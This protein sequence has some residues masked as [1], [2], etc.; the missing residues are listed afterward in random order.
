MAWTGGQFT[1]ANGSSEWVN[2]ANLLIGIEPGR[3]DAQDNDLATGINQCI[4]KD[5]SN[6]FTGD[7]NLG[8][9]KPTNIAAGTATAPALCVGGDVNTGVFA[10]AADTWA[11]A[12]NG[13]ER[14][15][16][17]STGFCSINE[18]PDATFRLRVGGRV[19]VGGQTSGDAELALASQL[20]P[21]NTAW[22]WSVRSDVGGNND[23]LKLIRFTSGSFVGTALQ[24][25]NSTGNVA[26]GTST[27]GG[28]LDVRTA[29]N[30]ADDFVVGVNL[31][32][33]NH[34]FKSKLIGR[35]TTSG[36]TA[37]VIDAGH[38]VQKQTSSL[39]YKT[40][41]QD[42]PKGLATVKQLRPVQYKGIND[43][44]KI[45]AGLIAE[46]VHDAGLTE[47]V[48]YD[49]NNEPEALAYGNMVALAFKAIQELSAE[50]E[51]LK[52]QLAVK[53][54]TL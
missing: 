17:N 40:D 25:Q 9:F 12:T 35:H 47:F 50:V 48:V 46:E 28:N 34:Y 6:A 30:D 38:I 31:S 49:S 18:T 45:F 26:I 7:A 1:R 15:R 39:K 23:D 21:A 43:G 36:G 11:V 29:Y 2:D 27:P 22:Q 20:T 4:N 16:V 3:H 44:D 37:V 14:V 5:G 19:R 13:T 53:T 54:E 32:P 33:G 52:T 10:P 41:V 51:A 42:Y 8:G 24:I